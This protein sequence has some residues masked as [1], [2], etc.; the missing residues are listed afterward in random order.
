MRL[1]SEITPEE[2]ELM[3]YILDAEKKSLK[4][5]TDTT[6]FDKNLINAKT[7]T[8]VVEG[9]VDKAKQLGGLE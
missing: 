3:E 1:R 7:D 9:I 5:V 8:I 4:K 6:G 2:E